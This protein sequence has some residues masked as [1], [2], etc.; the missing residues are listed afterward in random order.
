MPADTLAA[1]LS[2]QAERQREA[3]LIAGVHVG[4]HW[5]EAVLLLAA[6]KAAC[7]FLLLLY[8]LPTSPFLWP[9]EE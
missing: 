7:P 8:L 2:L 5:F 3:I 6:H 1:V 4:R 9:L